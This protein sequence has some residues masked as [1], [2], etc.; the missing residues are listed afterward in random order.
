MGCIIK[1]INLIA[2]ARIGK[3]EAKQKLIHRHRK[4]EVLEKMKMTYHQYM[5][6]EKIR[7]S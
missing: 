5:F 6:N 3:K 7:F 2:E 1:K 4:D